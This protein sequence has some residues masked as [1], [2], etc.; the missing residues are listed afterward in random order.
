M[1]WGWDGQIFQNSFKAPEK[2]WYSGFM[3]LQD[4]GIPIEFGDYP[5][6]KERNYGKSPFLMGNSTINGNFQWLC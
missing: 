6:V 3:Y 2:I 1:A 4:P 5:L